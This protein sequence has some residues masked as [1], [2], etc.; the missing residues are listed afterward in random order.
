MADMRIFEEDIASVVGLHIRDRTVAEQT[1]AAMCNLEWTNVDGAKFMATWRTAGDIVAGMRDC[2]EDYMDFYCAGS[3]GR[4]APELAKA[5]A[6][7][8]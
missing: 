2:G 3:E 7:L 8:G 4:V 5:M 1:Y 6:A